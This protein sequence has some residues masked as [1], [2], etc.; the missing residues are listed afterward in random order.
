M[1][2][3]LGIF[4]IAEVL[5]AAKHSCLKHFPARAGLSVTFVLR[6]RYDI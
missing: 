1:K 5:F 6:L 3:T 4:F 2:L